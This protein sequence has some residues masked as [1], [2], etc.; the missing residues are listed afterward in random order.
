MRVTPAVGAF[1][2]KEGAL[3]TFRTPELE[4]FRETGKKALY[5]TCVK[6]SHINSL[7][8]LKE[9]KWQEVLGPDASPK[10][11][12]RTLYKP[13]IEKRY[14]GPLLEDVALQ[15]A[16]SGGA[17]SPEF[18][19]LCAWLVSELKLYCRLEENVHATNCPS[20]AESFQL[21]MSGLLTELACPYSCLSRGDVTQRLLNAKLT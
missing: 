20:E 15:A 4:V 8:G 9:S 7:E 10:G 19:K 3:L 11:C 16:V 18:T 12:W 1:Q 14:Q 13:P 21:E 5:A 17:A 6:V 2:E